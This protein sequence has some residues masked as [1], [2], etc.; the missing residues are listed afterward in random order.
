MYI[1]DFIWLPNIVEKLEVKHHLIQ[2]EVEA[3]FFR[4]PKYRLVESGYTPGEDVYSAWG[5][6]DANRYLIVFFIY[7][8]PNRALIISARD[9][10]K[11][12]RKRYERK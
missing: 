3:V 7:K 12:E 1:D 9:M 8:R 2:E 10:D 6:T 5:K 11:K 4:Q